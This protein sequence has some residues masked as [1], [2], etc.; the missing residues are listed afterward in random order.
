M[1][2][3]RCSA[4]KATVLVVDDSPEIQRYLRTLLELDSYRVLAVSDGYEALKILRH[5]EIAD[6]V[7]LDVQMP[8]MD[9]LEVLRRMGNLCPK[10]KVI[11]CSG[12][13]DPGKVCQ[14]LSLG[15][16][17]YLVKPVQHLY[18]SAA[19][20]RCL[21]NLPAMRPKEKP[22]LFLMPSPVCAEHATLLPNLKS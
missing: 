1:A 10:V 5:A 7:L 18:L 6:V 3:I 16:H 2:C 21:Q 19:V 17:A 9:G 15:A 13:N 14:A 22:Q 12:V 4:I 20:E 11:M 8:G